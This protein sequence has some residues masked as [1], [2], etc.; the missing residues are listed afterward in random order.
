MPPPKLPAC[1]HEWGDPEYIR[2]KLFGVLFGS[3]QTCRR[4]RWRL[5]EN[6]AARAG[7]GTEFEMLPPDDP[8]ENLPALLESADATPA[9]IGPVDLIGAFLSGRKATTIR[10]YAKDLDDFA[11]F[12][13]MTRSSAVEL[14]VA[15]GPGNA[16]ATALAYRAHLDGRKLAPATICRRLAALRSV[17]R[18]ARRIGRIA[19]ALDV[20]SP[21][22]R[23]YRDTRGPG[24]HGVRKMVKQAGKDARTPKGRRDLAI[25]R[26]AYDG[27]LRRFEIAGLDLADVDLEGLTVS[28]TGKGQSEPV[29]LT[30]NP[31]VA[32]VLG[33]WIRARGDAPG[34]LF[35]RLDRAAGDGPPA[36][37]DPESINRITK[38]IGKKAGV[39]RGTN[40]HGLRH[41]AITKALDLAGG[42]V[43]RVQGFSRHADVKTV[44]KYN[45]NVQDGYGRLT[46]ML[47]DDLG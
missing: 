19:W 25:L 2:D 13:G 46:R 42:D 5:H 39:K 11:A 6:F 45:D 8:P 29:P 43:I 36:R 41:A 4:C 24:E 21:R 34:P 32:Q 3:I 18:M 14:L 37:M 1:D 10:A 31:T 47:G 20:D 9:T 40:A 15:G 28:V 7:E 12:L 26:L 30:I 17:V 23:A 27:G 22:S 16:N 38:A 33:E 44:L 35:T